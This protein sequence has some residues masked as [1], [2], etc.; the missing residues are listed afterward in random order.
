MWVGDTDPAAAKPIRR[1]ITTDDTEVGVS[2][3]TEAS[4]LLSSE[5]GTDVLGPDS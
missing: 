1:P 3:P 5:P 2:L 4:L